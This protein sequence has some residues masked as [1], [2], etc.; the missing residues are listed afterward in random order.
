MNKL[1]LEYEQDFD[2]WLDN[3]IRLLQQKRFTELDIA[4]LIEEL[5]DMGKSRKAEL[6]S[7]LI[8]LIAHLLKWQ[9]EFQTLK[10]RW[11][12]WEG[13]SWRNTIIE[14]RFQ[15]NR[16]IRKNPS[17][18]AYLPQAIQGVYA[19]SICL[20]TKES[21]LPESTFPEE[22]PYSLEQILDENFYPNGD[23]I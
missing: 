8:V 13:K 15:I 11:Q 23:D 17:L 14:Q 6:E 1:T 12:E 5:E 20:A 9:I 2:A 22:C 18:K 10:E 21:Q 16:T 7:R 19:D 4:H 3:H